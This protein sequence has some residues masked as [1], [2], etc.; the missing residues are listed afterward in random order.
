MFCRTASFNDHQSCLGIGKID[1]FSCK[2]PQNNWLI[3]GRAGQNL[4]IIDVDGTELSR[5]MGEHPSSKTRMS[6][7]CTSLSL[8]NFNE[9]WQKKIIFET[10]KTKKLNIKFNLRGFH[11][12]DEGVNDTG[13][14]R[15]KFL[16]EKRFRKLLVLGRERHLSYLF[17]L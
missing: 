13:S 12:I 2:C 6:L 5:H 15:G 7:S 1:S 3:S 10:F 4:F 14:K 17:S 11:M 16:I 9:D 8:Q